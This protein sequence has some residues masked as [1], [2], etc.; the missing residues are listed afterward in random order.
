MRGPRADLDVGQGTLV[1]R[2]RERDGALQ[3]ADE[4]LFRHRHEEQIARPRTEAL[5]ALGDGLA[6]QDGDDPSALAAD[7]RRQHLHGGGEGPARPSVEDSHGVGLRSGS[8]RGTAVRQRYRQDVEATPFPQSVGKG[9]EHL[10]IG[11]DE[12]ARSRHGLRA[13]LTDLLM[14]TNRNDDR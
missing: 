9:R 6:L 10:R 8:R 4:L 13:Y 14:Q 1:G 7:S 3:A 5:V 11:E 12:Q 2:V